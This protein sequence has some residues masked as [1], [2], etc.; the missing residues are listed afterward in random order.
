MADR[1]H[2]AIYI[3][4]RMFGESG[5]PWKFALVNSADAVDAIVVKLEWCVRTENK[6]LQRPGAHSFHQ[7]HA[8]DVR[9]H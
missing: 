3:C 9:E 1:R 5:A 4:F 2:E 6:A 7:L 8:T